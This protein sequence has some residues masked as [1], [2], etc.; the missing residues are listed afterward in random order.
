MGTQGLA[1]T[2]MHALVLF[3]ILSVCNSLAALS[4]H[5]G[6]Y[7]DDE[8]NHGPA[9][10]QSEAGRDMDTIVATHTFFD[11]LSGQRNTFGTRLWDG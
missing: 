7:F 4:V 10:P 2:V 6:L 8:Q 9:A 5:T 11:T 3:S 1:S